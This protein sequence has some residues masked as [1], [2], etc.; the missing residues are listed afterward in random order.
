[1]PVVTRNVPSLVAEGEYKG[2]CR[3]VQQEWSKPRKLPDGTMTKSHPV[4]KMPLHLPDGKMVIHRLHLTENT[5]E[6][7][8]QACKSGGLEIPDGPFE[9]GTDDLEGRIFHFCVVHTEWNGIKR[10][11]VNFH[12]ESYALQVNPALEKVGFPNEAPRGVMLRSAPGSA[13]KSEPPPKAAGS[14]ASQP[15]TPSQPSDSTEAS[16]EELGTLTEKEFAEALAYA[17][18]LREKKD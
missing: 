5:E 6:L 17:K 1:M 13:P 2:Q 9:L 16:L 18:K 15:S 14:G 10:A 4:F 8:V 11:E 7:V 3:K 12:A